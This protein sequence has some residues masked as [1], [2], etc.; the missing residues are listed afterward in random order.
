MNKSC[1][2]SNLYCNEFPISYIGLNLAVKCLSMG[3]S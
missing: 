1:K 2:Y 3:A